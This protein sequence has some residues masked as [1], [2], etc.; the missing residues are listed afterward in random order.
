MVMRIATLVVLFAAVGL[1]VAS[2]VIE[3]Q[4]AEGSLLGLPED[5]EPT[6]T[7]GTL[8]RLEKERARQAEQSRGDKTRSEREVEKW[9]RVA[10]QLRLSSAIVLGVGAVLCVLVLLG[11]S[12]RR[13]S[14]GRPMYVPPRANR[15]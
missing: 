6:S 14:E 10:E 3:W 8:G 5:E 7:L 9:L 15:D 1:F 12:N 11:R 13:D 4:V 2:L